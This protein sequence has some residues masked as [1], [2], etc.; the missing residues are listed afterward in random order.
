MINVNFDPSVAF[1]PFNEENFPSGSFFK[2]GLTKK[3]FALFLVIEWIYD[4]EDEC[5][6]PFAKVIQFSDGGVKFSDF[7]EDPGPD[8]L[9]MKNIDITARM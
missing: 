7:V 1:L 4:K 6:C 9:P 2:F 5:D 3:T 8:Y